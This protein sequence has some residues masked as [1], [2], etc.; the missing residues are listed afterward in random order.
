[1]LVFRGLLSNTPKITSSASLLETVKFTELSLK[2][3]APTPNLCMIYLI[4]CVS[5]ICRQKVKINLNWEN[6][7]KKKKK[8]ENEI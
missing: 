1:M 4:K 6:N 3:K 7:N 5:S 2:E 8:I